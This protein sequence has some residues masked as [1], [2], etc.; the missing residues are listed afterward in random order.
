MTATSA[1][2]CSS[3]SSTFTSNSNW[4]A[5]QVIGVG[6]DYL[7]VRNWEVRQ[8]GFFTRHDIAAVAKDKKS[9]VLEPSGAAPRSRVD[10]SDASAGMS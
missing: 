3:P 5:K 1:M 6:A 2:S 4:N 8:G 10:G 9:F 7:T